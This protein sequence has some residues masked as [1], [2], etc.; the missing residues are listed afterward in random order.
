MRSRTGLCGVLLLVLMT[1]APTGSA[2]A[3]GGGI[4]VTLSAPKTDI[5]ASAGVWVRVTYSNMADTNMSILKWQTPVNGLEA[6]LFDVAADGKPVDYIGRLVKRGPPTPG[7]Y[8]TIA[9]GDS[10]SFSVNLARSY[11]FSE[12]AQYSVAYNFPLTQAKALASNDLLLDVAGRADPVASV[13]TPGYTGCTP[14]RQNQLLTALGSASTYASGAATYFTSKRSG[15]RYTEWFGAMDATRYASVKS[16]FT[17]ISNALET[18]TISFDCTCTDTGVYA[19]V[20]PNQPYMIYLCGAFWGAPNTG[21]DSRAGT[22][23]HEMSH[24]SVLADTDDHVYGQAGARSLAISN[25]ARA[26][27]NADNHGYF[28]ENTPTLANGPVLGLSASTYEFPSTS[29]GASSPA[30]QFTLT[31]TGDSSLTTGAITVTG[32]FSVSTGC[33]NKTLAA[34]ASCTFTATFSPASAG[35]KS[36]T[37][38]IP[39]NTLT[40]GSISLTGLAGSSG[41]TL[42]PSSH[43]FGQQRVGTT[44][45]AQTFRVTNSTGTS[46]TLSTI[47]TTPGF[48]VSSNCNGRVLPALAFCEF[49]ATFTPTSAGA[50]TG[51]ISVASNASGAPHI[52]ALTGTG[53]E[54]TLNLSRTSYDFGKLPVGSTSSGQPVTITNPGNLPVS[55]GVISATQDFAVTSTCNG[56]TINPAE[57]CTFTASFTPTATGARAGTLTIPSNAVGAPH[58]VS[59]TGAGSVSDPPP[60]GELQVSEQLHDFGQVPVGSSSVSASVTVRST[61]TSPVTVESVQTNGPFAVV[62]SGCVGV[63]VAPAQTCAVTMRFTPMQAGTQSGSVLITSTAQN[64]P[65]RIDL[66]GSG[67]R[68]PDAPTSVT[69]RAISNGSRILVRVFPDRGRDSQWTFRIQKRVG[70]EWTTLR[71][72]HTTL[73]SKHRL[74]V[75]L[76][77]GRY[78]AVVLEQPGYQSSAS[79]VV[80]LTR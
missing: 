56:A 57:S 71:T 55:V 35:P 45:T 49:T 13:I 77:K 10:L 78:R 76:P 63:T 70:R 19:Y 16:N 2:A 51:T 17:K 30:R 8:L 12:T 50:T 43:T 14:L 37:I 64:S 42:T 36:G 21:T 53:V 7:D 66:I 5:V 29:A 59:L 41:V 65:V 31:N 11:S 40:T 69:A 4:E 61:G 52:I 79:K 33:N 72:T 80:R 58:M 47:T 32:E 22:L 34:N 24:F 9:P 38:S 73:G 28:A 60:V 18:A 75:D 62:E 3:A 1:L 67:A 23:I 27:T 48:A 6:P 20:Y 26:V 39:N 68:P 46:L 15:P 44:S 74:R 54:P 25:P